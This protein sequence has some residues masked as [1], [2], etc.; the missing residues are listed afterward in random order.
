MNQFI[1]SN[2]TFKLLL[3]LSKY[4]TL[5][6]KKKFLFLII[7]S[8]FV[9]LFETS[10]IFILAPFLSALLDPDFF[11]NQDNFISIFLNSRIQ[12]NPIYTLGFLL[13]FL[14]ISSTL[15]RSSYVYK[16]RSF[17]ASIGTK[18]SLKAYSN[19]I[20]QDYKYHV[21][22][23]STE[24][25][26]NLTYVNLLITGVLQPGLQIISSSILAIGILTT[27]LYLYTLESFLTIGLLIFIYS[28]ITILFRK[29]VRKISILSDIYTK[30]LLKLQSE[31]LRSV[32]DII[33]GKYQNYF[34]NKYKKIDKPLR[35]L[36]VQISLLTTIPRY[37]VECFAICMISL[38]GIYFVIIKQ[39][40]EVFIL[41]GV[42]ALAFQRLL[43]TIQ[44]FYGSLVTLR[45]Y[46]YCLVGILDLLSNYMISGNTVHENLYEPSSFIKIS[47]INLSNISYKYEDQKLAL[48]KINLTIDKGDKIGIVGTTGGGKSTLLN[49]ILGLI[50]PSNGTITF[51]NEYE[52]NSQLL[53]NWHKQISHVPQSIFLS[54]TSIRENI[55]FGINKNEISKIKLDKAA[56]DSLLDSFVQDL[57]NKYETLVGEAGVKLSGGQ[58]QRI[59]IARALYRDNDYLILDEATNALDAVTE[60]LLINRL[61]SYR[62]LTLIAICHR[63]SVLKNFDKIIILE[64]GKIIDI[65][66]FNELENKSEMFRQLLRLDQL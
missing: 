58:R 51:N 47:K 9:S 55:A 20:R 1:V 19:V 35:F 11:K 44:Q 24:I 12:S 28:L 32:K 14:S 53:T 60:N 30:D 34:E 23:K 63:I 31:S 46:K 3:E 6:D 66:T 41:L 49:I 38:L 7:H 40:N 15:I 22:K 29:K 18:L 57:P 16:E 64:K 65:G 48:D 42:L 37:I 50:F 13:I 25:I 17:A 26:S 52:L 39:N 45:S 8:L 61:I 33:L 10:V 56:K 2:N 59:G 54:D 62:S 36:Q 5:K 43:P 4:T 27:I 21:T